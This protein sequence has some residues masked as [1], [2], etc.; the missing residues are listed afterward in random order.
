MTIRSRKGPI[1]C[2]T[3][4]RRG[5]PAVMYLDSITIAVCPRCEM[6]VY[7]GRAA[8]DELSSLTLTLYVCTY[9]CTEG[10]TAIGVTVLRMS[11][12]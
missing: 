2:P 6:K 3:I 12:R 1:R 9:I 5:Q 7:M 10:V 11:V 8:K 4:R